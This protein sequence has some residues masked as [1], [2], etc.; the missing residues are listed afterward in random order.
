MVS[1]PSG[2]GTEKPVD[3]RTEESMSATAGPAT[4]ESI[5]PANGEVVDSFEIFTDEQIDAALEL[6][7]GAF[8]E[9]RRTPWARR[10]EL[11][12]GVARELRAAGEEIAETVSREMG[13]PITEGQA[14]VEKCAWAAEYYAE[15]GGGFR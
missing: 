3:D 7:H 13:K 6:S 11:M 8:G 10:A 9:G 1:C 14:E 5:D 4:V 12:N 2:G 15:H